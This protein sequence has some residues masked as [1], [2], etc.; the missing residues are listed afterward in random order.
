MSA[1]IRNDEELATRTAELANK[2]E[3]E[4]STEKEIVCCLA[5]H[6]L[7]SRACENLSEREMEEIKE[8]AERLFVSFEMP[9]PSVPS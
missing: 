6:L 9:V 7:W 1:P 4:L 8:M 2:L 5:L 3:L